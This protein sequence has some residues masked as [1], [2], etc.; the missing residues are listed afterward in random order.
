MAT[1]DDMK[2]HMLATFAPKMEF[3]RQLLLR[4]CAIEMR[5]I[6][7]RGE[8]LH[9]H[10]RTAAEQAALHT[11]A[12]A[13]ATWNSACAAVT[14]ALHEAMMEWMDEYYGNMENE[15]ADMEGHFA[16]RWAEW[17]RDRILELS[18]PII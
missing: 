10:S 17:I 6:S 8:P 11:A 3:T 5:Y 1:P 12:R 2:E 16:M 4:R 18:P 14:N 15:L 7:L 9:A 13:L